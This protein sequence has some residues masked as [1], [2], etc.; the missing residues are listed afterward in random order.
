MKTCE[1]CGKE[2]E[3]RW[4]TKLEN[5][6]VKA[7]S[8]CRNHGKTIRKEKK[9]KKTK[10]KKKKRKKPKKTHRKKEKE[11]DPDY[12]SKI[13]KAREN[14]EMTQEELSNEIKE[15][16]SRIKKIE[17]GKMTP[18]REITRKLEK[19]LDVNLLKDPEN[20]K[21]NKKRKK[22]TKKAT[23]GDVIELKEE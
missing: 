10:K 23:I 1:V 22:K 9:Q 3:N 20:I 8:E 6:K 7:C 21:V 18:T 19:K 4:I 13:K 16:E 14:K 2:T 15:S 12:T 5:S 17:K 11:I